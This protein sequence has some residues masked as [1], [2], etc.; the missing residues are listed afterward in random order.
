MGRRK[1]SGICDDIDDGGDEDG[2]V[3]LLVVTALTGEELHP[4]GF[5]SDPGLGFAVYSVSAKVEWLGVWGRLAPVDSFL[6]VVGS[7]IV[8]Y[9]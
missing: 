2:T 9:L 8:I 1:A 4:F 6:G 5:S 7:D 3:V